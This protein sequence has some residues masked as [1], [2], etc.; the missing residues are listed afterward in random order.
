MSAQHRPLK[1]AVT[2]PWNKPSTTFIPVVA[3][4]ARNEEVLL[5]R[6]LAAL[7]RQTV[8]PRLGAP[9]DVV[10]VL[11][12]ITD[13]SRGA[14]AEAA[15]QASGLRIVVEDI[16]YPAERAHVGSA[17]RRAMEIA[18]G[19]RPDGVILTT[20]AD[21]VPA[22]DWI[23]ANLRAI[24]AGADL[25]GGRITGDP[26]DEA[27]LG[28]GFQRRARTHARFKELRDEL[29]ALIDPLPHDPWPRHQDHTGASLAV[30]ANVH[31]AVGGLDPLPFR[32][33]LAFVSKV[34]AAGFW[35]R[36]PLDVRVTVSA[37]TL[38]RAP[39]GMAD[40]LRN[41]L[42]EEERGT[43]IRLNLST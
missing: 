13:G 6:L 15:R 43:P 35:L 40:C 10:I 24:V 41:W 20:D 42:H 38:G 16:I 26:E 14:V 34:R 7:N 17:R 8:V 27:R 3:V 23:E 31:T 5:P 11:N 21:T 25:V 9:L 28:E 1:P 4:P 33:D 36:H 32:E 2:R 22:D 29:A 18:A 37:R 30:R 39:G 12:N 19:L